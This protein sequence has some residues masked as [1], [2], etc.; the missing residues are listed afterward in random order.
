MSEYEQKR[1]FL[2]LF[3]GKEGGGACS[4]EGGK[5]SDTSEEGIFRNGKKVKEEKRTLR[6]VSKQS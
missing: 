6:V 4:Q 5:S 1:G 2:N 3:C